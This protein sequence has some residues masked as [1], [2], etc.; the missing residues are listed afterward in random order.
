M[1]I[2]DMTGVTTIEPLKYSVFETPHATIEPNRTCNIECRLCYALDRTS[3]KSLAQVTHE[4]DLVLE[5][6]N[7]QAITLLGGEPTLH[8]DI[9]E[10]ISYIKRCG[11]VCQL[12]T[13]GV[14]FL[15]DESDQVL[16]ALIESGVDRILLHVDQGQSHVHNDVEKTRD[17]LFAK[18]ETLRVHFSLS[19]TV[20]NQSQGTISTLIKRYARYKFFDGILAILARDPL[21]PGSENTQLVDEY[22]SISE[23]LQIQPVTYIPSNLGDEYVSWLVYSYYINANTY[24]IFPIS[25]RFSKILRKLHRILKGHH[26]FVVKI[27]PLLYPVALLGTGL[28]EAL[29]EPRK[30]LKLCRVLKNSSLG[31]A[32]RFHYILLQNPPEFDPEE[33]QFQICYHCPDATIRNGMLTSVC[34]ADQINPLSGYSNEEGIREDLCQIVYENLEE[35]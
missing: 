14:V 8:P 26:L 19:I 21:Y 12:L 24:S 11:L 3:V 4:I 5:K 35:V 28:L 20:F 34:V 30:L 31:R 33:N 10:I 13:N 23:E 1:K 16:E 15:E 22:R 32:V 18:L 25:R 9:G 17:S 27:D 29:G 7:L 6:R 2:K